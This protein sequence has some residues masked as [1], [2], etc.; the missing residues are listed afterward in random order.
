MCLYCEASV[1]TPLVEVRCLTCSC[2]TSAIHDFSRA[3]VRQLLRA[4][5]LPSRQRCMHVP[6]PLPLSVLSP[7]AALSLG[8][9]GRHSSALA[10]F[11]HWQEWDAVACTVT[12]PSSR[13][14]ETGVSDACARCGASQRGG[15]AQ[16][17][18]CTAR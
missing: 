4:L 18:A 16:R 2:Y 17:R 5:S 8:A 7:A 12:R 15:R 14:R 1:P 13:A 11:P 3:R 9:L 10:V 6:P